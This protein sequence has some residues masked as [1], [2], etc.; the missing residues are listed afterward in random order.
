MESALENANSARW[1]DT[2]AGGDGV[3]ESI[4]I[5]KDV[6]EIIQKEDACAERKEVCK[7]EIFT[8]HQY[9]P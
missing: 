4:V 2:R 7:S 9:V 5:G 3:L 1:R 8:I 6:Q